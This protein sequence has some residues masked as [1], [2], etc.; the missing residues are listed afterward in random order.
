MKYSEAK[1]YKI[2]NSVSD[3]V[4]IGSTTQRYLCNRFAQ[5]KQ[6][7]KR[8]FSGRS[9][10]KVT[11]FKLL[12]DDS[13]IIT[14]IEK[15]SCDD[16][17]VLHKREREIIEATPNCVN[18]HIPT[19]TKYEHGSQKIY[20]EACDCQI[21]LKYKLTHNKLQKHITN[22]EGKKKDIHQLEE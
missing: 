3:L 1:L 6:T 20:C 17:N 21:T 22:Y 9:T 4:Y 2:T 14:L 5:H 16:I 18:K 15:F 8:Y 13:A 7:Y 19:R 12:D 10:N 11:S